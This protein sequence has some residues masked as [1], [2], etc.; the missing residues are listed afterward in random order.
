MVPPVLAGARLGA[1]AATQTPQLRPQTTLQ[2]NA[3]SHQQLLAL[4]HGLVAASVRLATMSRGRWPTKPKQRGS[5][6]V[7]HEMDLGGEP[8]HEVI[9][10][11]SATSVLQIATA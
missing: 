2:Q 11:Y 9:A 10:K 1:P 6:G 3:S 8:L 5:D 7:G 4:Q